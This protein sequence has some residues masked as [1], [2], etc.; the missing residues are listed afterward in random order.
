MLG[1]IELVTLRPAEIKPEDVAELR[2]LG[3]TA[4]AVYDAVTICG[5][6]SFYN[7]WIDATGVHDMSPEEYGQS[8]KRLA[9]QGYIKK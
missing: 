3:W 6:F 7:R 9:T 8:G 5:L 1:Y 4:E 2:K